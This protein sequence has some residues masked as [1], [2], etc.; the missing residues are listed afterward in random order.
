MKNPAPSP[1]LMPLHSGICK[2]LGQ[3]AEA[4]RNQ[5]R[6][7][8]MSHQLEVPPQKKWTGL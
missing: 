3:V 7:W 8:E 5:E 6:L 2:Q 4:T 1:V